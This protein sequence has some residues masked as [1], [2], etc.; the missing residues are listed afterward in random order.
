MDR[1]DYLSADPLFS[2]TWTIVYVYMC[3]ELPFKPIKSTC[4][5]VSLEATNKNWLLSMMN[6][7][8][9]KSILILIKRK[10]G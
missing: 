3:R 9:I 8:S 7:I 6:D 10:A 5:Q 1:A 2:L 4:S